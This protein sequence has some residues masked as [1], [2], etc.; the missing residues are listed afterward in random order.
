MKR[1]VEL[2]KR[3]QLLATTVSNDEE[4]TQEVIDLATELNGELDELVGWFDPN[5]T[6]YEDGYVYDGELIEVAKQFK[7]GEMK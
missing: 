2:L 1:L 4:I 3:A 7:R 6:S 5:W